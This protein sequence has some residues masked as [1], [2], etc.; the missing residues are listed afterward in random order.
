MD[1]DSTEKDMLS[2]SGMREQSCWDL[3][4][5]AQ[6]YSCQGKLGPQDAGFRQKK[7]FYCTTVVQNQE[8]VSKNTGQ[9]QRQK[10]A[11]VKMVQKNTKQRLRSI[12]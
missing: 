7:G 6:T 3:Y 5:Q 12:K 9:R 10:Q 2:C 4:M 1:Q 8:T 11:V